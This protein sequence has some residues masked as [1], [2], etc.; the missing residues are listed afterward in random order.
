M[1]NAKHVA[2]FGAL[3]FVF[4]ALPVLAQSP[5]VIVCCSN[6]CSNCEG[7][8]SGTV[9][10][11]D[12]S[13]PSFMTIAGNPITTSGTLAF[14]FASQTQNLVFAAPNG[15][16]GVPLFRALV[17]DDV[18]ELPQSKVTNLV[19]DLAGKQASGNYI[20]GTT[21]DVVANGPG[22]VVATIQANSVELGADTTG[23]YAGSSTEGGAATTAD[24]L[25]ANPTNCGAGNYPLGIDASGNVEDCTPVSAGGVGG[26]TGSVDNAVP[27]ADGA[28]GDTLQGSDVTISDVAASK[29]TMVTSPGVAFTVAAGDPSTAASSQA[30]KDT[31]IAASNA[32]AGNTNAGA[33][34]GGN[35]NITAG[36]AARF[37][38][39][40]GNGGYINL[41]AGTLIGG[42]QDGQVNVIGSGSSSSSVP[43]LGIGCSPSSF[44]QLGFGTYS[45]SNALTIVNGGVVAH[46]GG[47]VRLTSSGQFTL[48]SSSDPA[49][50]DTRLSRC[51]V[52]C[53]QFGDPLD[54]TNAQHYVLSG[55]STTG[56]NLAGGDVVFTSGKGT[57]TGNASIL[58]LQTPVAGSSG[59]TAHTLASRL[60]LGRVVTLTDATATAVINVP[61]A[62][63]TI[64]GGT[65]SYTIEVGN[66]TAYQS[67]RGSVEF[68]AVN[69]GGT[70]TCELGTPVQIEVSPTGTLTNT[71]TCTTAGTNQITFNLNA[72]TDGLS[73]SPTLKAT[74]RIDLDGG[75]GDVSPF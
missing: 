29:V 2:L 68:A 73:G 27:R 74:P 15:I 5:T 14:A 62:S 7:G 69:E 42:G 33:A 13:V 75:T 16:D 19:T 11:V 47:S 63:N 59:T 49:N 40:N 31:T 34:N 39:G 30:G 66:G 38:S 46:L 44:C 8:G 52:R 67:I 32:T 57:G 1:R 3:L 70:E 9:T 22:S 51:G 53:W 37:T 45:N 48:S 6:Q 17:A 21:G 20:T 10:S 72:D 56:T 4:L 64:T 23:G 60:V 28:L 41:D 61:I 26:S 65:F 71:V 55:F 54:A 12:A 35:V 36:N 50:A 18:P 25:S 24:A 58:E 43:L